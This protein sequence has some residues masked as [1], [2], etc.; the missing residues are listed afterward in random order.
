MKKIVSGILSAL[1]FTVPR[2]FDNKKISIPHINGLKVG[3]SGEPW[4]LDLLKKILP[5]RQGGAFIDV[6]VNLGQTL[7]KL[8]AA[9]PHR[10]YIGFEPNPICVSYVQKL[11]AANTYQNCTLIPAGLFPD[12]QILQLNLYQT[13]DDDS[14][15]SMITELRPVNEIKQTMYVPVTEFDK[16]AALLNLDEIGFIKID[17]EGAEL[18]VFETLLQ[19]ITSWR[20]MILVEILPV[21][22]ELDTIKIARQE[23]IEKMFRNLDFDFYRINKTSKAKFTHLGKIT[24]I[25]L[26][27]NNLLR[28]YLIAP[29]EMAPQLAEL[30][31]I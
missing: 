3:I 20:P 30:T 14:S 25:G 31:S 2:R 16:V 22:D 1:N 11:I 27:S 18:E 12:S 21:R 9:E 17:V 5:K 8:K 6:G 23:K 10:Q 24:A 26:H 29:T 19:V 7:I 28:D 15:A 4:M 13:N